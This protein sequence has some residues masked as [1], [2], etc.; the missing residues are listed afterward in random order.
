[1]QKWFYRLFWQKFG[2]ST[3][4]SGQQNGGFPSFVSDFCWFVILIRFF[5]FIRFTWSYAIRFRRNIEIAV[6]NE[7]KK[8]AFKIWFLHMTWLAS[9]Q[10]ETISINWKNKC[11]ESCQTNVNVME[12]TFKDVRETARNHIKYDFQRK[13]K[14][15]SELLTFF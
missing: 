9:L 14:T 10:H 5:F 7:Q 1:M 2:F 12:T 11:C 3:W 8:T 13:M 15:F 6:Q 4:V